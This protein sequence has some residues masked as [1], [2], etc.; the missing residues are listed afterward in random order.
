M[1]V[2]GFLT[3]AVFGLINFSTRGFQHA[4]VKQGLNGESEAIQ[5]K[6]RSD[7]RA[8]HFGTVAVL[9]RQESLAGSRLVSRDCVAFA[10]LSDWSNPANFLATG[11][12]R[13]NR[14]TVWY[15][16]RGESGRLVRQVINTGGPLPA[17]VP[18][19]ALDVN[20][21][22]TPL[23]NDNLLQS[24]ILS[25]NVLSFSVERDEPSQLLDLELILLRRAGRRA[26]SGAPIE[27]TQESVFS[28]DAYNTY[29]RL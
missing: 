24:S 23:D 6:L 8:S 25:E 21:S 5:A 11:L 12:P 17:P 20:V 14:Y 4:V 18:Y 27:E 28:L 22:D 1:A 26:T 2:L 16:T 15:A 19:S 29:P 3:I 7:Y 13:W 9:N 10:S